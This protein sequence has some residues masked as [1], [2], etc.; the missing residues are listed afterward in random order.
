MGLSALQHF[1]DG[2]DRSAA[3]NEARNELRRDRLLQERARRLVA[4]NRARGS[5]LFTFDDE[6]RIAVPSILDYPRGWTADRIAIAREQ[7]AAL[8]G[9]I[10]RS[11]TLSMYVSHY[12]GEQFISKRRRWEGQ[13]KFESVLKD[14][15]FGQE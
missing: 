14:L 4:D 1:R 12:W 5:L 11:A 13:A 7:S 8:V 9:W 15:G 2:M 10:N 6:G 3:H